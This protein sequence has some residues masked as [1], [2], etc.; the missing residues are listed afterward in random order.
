MTAMTAKIAT[1]FA[2][3][4]G[5]LASSP[6]VYLTNAIA[7]VTAARV[8]LKGKEPAVVWRRLEQLATA[9]KF[10]RTCLELACPE[11]QGAR[12]DLIENNGDTTSWPRGHKVET[13]TSKGITAKTGETRPAQPK[14]SSRPLAAFRFG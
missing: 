11:R 12:N 1:S 5:H 6:A 14:V 9:E 8:G 13:G 2:R 3:E 4:V 7:R 10:A